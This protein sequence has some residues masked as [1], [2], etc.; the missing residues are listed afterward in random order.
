MRALRLRPDT[1]VVVGGLV[2]IAAVFL[3]VSAR[4]PP[5]FYRDE[6]A[7]A[8]N[9]YTLA[10][11]GKDEYGARLPLFIKSFGDYKSPLYV[12]L[13]AAVFRVTGPSTAV[14][15]TFSAVLG[16]GAILVLY[17]LALAIS[18]KRLPA[19]AVALLAGLSP[20]L[21]EISRLVFEVALEPLLLALF[22]LVLQRAA[23]GPW[24]SRHSVA[25]AL[26]LGA[27]AY[28][29]QAG[30]VLA[31]LFALGLLLFFRQGRGRQIAL[32]WAVFLAAMAPIGVYAL[33]HPRAIQARYD[34]VTYIHGGMSP[35]DIAGQFLLHYAKNLNL[36][37]W[38]V[39]GDPNLRQHV[40]GAGSLF[41]V[42][43]GLALAG[44]AFVLLRRRSDPWWRFVCYGVLV[45]PV[46]ASLTDQTIHSLRMIALPI[47][48]PL[49]ALPA[50]DLIAS[51]PQRRVRTALLGA[52]IAAF[53]VEAIHWQ[54]VFHQNGDS[55]ARQAAFEV[56]AHPVVEAA[57][58]RGGTIY[59]YR[60]DHADYIDSLFYGAIAGR[61]RSSIIVL[62]GNAKPP[63]G[64][65]VVGV[66]G[67]CSACRRIAEDGYFEAYFTPT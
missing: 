52:L 53:A 58:H 29:Y 55:P 8:Y 19:L 57:L 22:L 12:Y 24:K 63:A 66:V 46:A 40:P 39:H 16:L 11:S 23:T 10:T 37:A 27:I 38:L 13:L 30:R 60:A 51:L 34:A 2:L 59:A 33:I 45:T 65:L 61:P 36:W 21:F 50:F 62:D 49:L 7:I 4:N 18:R 32:L 64:A 20:W 43:V 31:P 1:L 6:S 17:L 35:V 5:G 3:T 9:A 26:L 67:E 44:T 48:L 47:F 41:F 14:A 54:I 28:A 15:R 42:E 25:I 56:Q